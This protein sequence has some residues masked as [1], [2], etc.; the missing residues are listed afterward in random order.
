[1]P[2]TPRIIAFEIS[3]VLGS[4][5]PS[6]LGPSSSNTTFFPR[7]RPSPTYVGPC[8]S[9]LATPC[10]RKDVPQL[11]A[12]TVPL[13]EDMAQVHLA[14]DLCHCR[15]WEC[16]GEFNC[17]ACLTTVQLQYELTCFPDHIWEQ[18]VQSIA[19]H[20]YECG[21]RGF[22]HQAGEKKS[23][24]GYEV[25]VGIGSGDIVT[26]NGPFQAGEFLDIT[27]FCECF[28]GCKFL[29]LMGR[30]KVRTR[31]EAQNSDGAVSVVFSSTSR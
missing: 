27:I 14:H 8:T 4:I 31:N 1:M 18:E 25:A 12:T 17:F 2:L 20:A 26:V 3:L 24:L 28:L 9:L 13:T 11:Q 6:P 15:S 16:S 7:Q 21:L 10:R 23:T 29:L 5:L 19:W 22:L 30:N